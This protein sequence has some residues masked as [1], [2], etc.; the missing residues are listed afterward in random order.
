MA[1]TAKPS[2]A[3]DVEYSSKNVYGFDIACMEVKTKKGEECSGA[4]TG[5]YSTVYFSKISNMDDKQKENLVLAVSAEIKSLM[6]KESKSILVAGLGNK[7][8]TS[9]SIGP[10]CV[11]KL[12]V[13]RHISIYESDI[14]KTL[15]TQTISALAPGVLSQTGIES[16]EIFKGTASITRPDTVIIVDSLCARAPER[17]ASTIQISNTGLTPGSGVGNKRH[18]IDENTLGCSVISIGIPTV[19]SSSTLVYDALSKSSLEQF[20]DEMEKILEN[21]RSF[22]VTLNE[23]DEIT[24]ILSEILSRAIYD[25]AQIYIE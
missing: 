8:L 5:K 14:F 3:D 6:T 24:D 25:S 18:T 20:G 9:D 7:Y 17:L 19:V 15:N 21:G 16:A 2:S 23:I 1:Q 13:T 12:N 11:S 10:K 4:K 22:Y